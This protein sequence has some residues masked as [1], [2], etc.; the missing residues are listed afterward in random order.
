MYHYTTVVVVAL[1]CTSVLAITINNNVVDPPRTGAF[2]INQA[3]TQL[4]Y[5]YSAY[6]PESALKPNFNCYFCQYNKSDTGGFVTSAVVSSKLTNTYGYIGNRGSVAEIVFR[7]TTNTENWILNLDYD[8]VSPYTNLP[9]SFVH[10]GFYTDYTSLQGPVKSAL[11]ALM[12]KVN[13]TQIYV[14][15][16][17]LGG[18]LATL[19]AYD[20]A[21]TSKVPVGIYTFGSPRVGNQVFSDA[22]VK[23]IPNSIRVTNMKDPV[24]HLPPLPFNFHH[25]SQEVW[26]SKVGTYKVCDTTGEDKSCAD[27]VIAT[28]VN[29]H[30][31]YL[32]IAV[33]D[34]KC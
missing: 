32:G 28:D 7:G 8:H 31:D 3:Y 22:F 4:M 16:H 25:V 26:W 5:A 30:L 9:G 13:I 11:S 27:S 12:T 2:D 23:L 14:T 21:Q 18:A 15:G 19:C 6:C 29:D 24:P 10:K 33:H 1:L 17:S 20:I 34:G